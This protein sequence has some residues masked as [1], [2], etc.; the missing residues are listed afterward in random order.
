MM[1]AFEPSK[2]N[3]LAKY[4][5]LWIGI[6]AGLFAPMIVFG[7]YCLVNWQFVTERVFTAFFLSMNSTLI[8]LISLCTL[9]NLGIFYLAINKNLYKTARGIIL[10]TFIYA[11]YVFIN[12]L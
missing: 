11:I 10:S 2:P 3:K 12:K 7:I 1:P 9:I 5:Q 6:T 4:D 8:G